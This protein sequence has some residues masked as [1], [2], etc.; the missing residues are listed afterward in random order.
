MPENGCPEIFQPVLQRLALPDGVIG[1]D[2]VVLARRPAPGQ[3]LG[4]QTE[5]GGPVELVTLELPRIALDSDAGRVA[6]AAACAAR[7]VATV[8]V[9]RALTGGAPLWLVGVD[10]ACLTRAAERRFV[11]TGAVP[12]IVLNA[13]AT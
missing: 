7:D 12:D 4:A 1:P 13:P 2:L 11:L 5:D 9:D 8:A 3:P 10:A 6:I